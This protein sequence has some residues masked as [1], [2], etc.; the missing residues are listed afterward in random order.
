LPDGLGRR[1]CA[2]VPRASRL[3]YC[4]SFRSFRFGALPGPQVGD[5]TVAWG[6]INRFVELL[7]L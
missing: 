2:Y 4:Y 1:T 3:H 7:S 6:D 5:L